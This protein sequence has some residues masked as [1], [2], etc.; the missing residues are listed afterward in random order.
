MSSDRFAELFEKARESGKV[1]E[2]WLSELQTQFE[3]SPLRQEVKA[4]KE[5]LKATRDK[6]STLRDGLL[7][8]K[9][10]EMGI[11]MKP[12]AFRIPDDLDPTDDEKVTGWMVEMGLTE[13]KPTTD[14]AERATHDRIA[15]VSTDTGKNQPSIADLDPSKMSM[16][17][18]DAKV[19]QIQAL[20]KT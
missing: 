15:N 5:E 10:K 18:F 20:N 6:L 11:G 9:F 19:A 7:S 12:Q 3:A 16:E 14:P 17:E 1:D 8:V 2:D 4:T 13:A